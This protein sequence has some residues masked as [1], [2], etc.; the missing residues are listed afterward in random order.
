VL[1]IDAPFRRDS[2]KLF[3]FHFDSGSQ[4][5]PECNHERQDAK[6]PRRRGI[7]QDKQWNRISASFSAP[8][9]LGVH[10]RAVDEKAD[11]STQFSLLKTEH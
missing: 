7:R 8:R 1:R 2:L 5:A 6:T 9:R 4:L 3:S 11:E 10:L